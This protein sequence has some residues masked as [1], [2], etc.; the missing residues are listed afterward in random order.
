[1]VAALPMLLASCQPLTSQAPPPSACAGI[2]RRFDELIDRYINAAGEAIA[3]VEPPQALE[4][5]RKAVQAG[6]RAASI[7][8]VGIPL[9]LRARADRFNVATVRQVCGFAEANRHPLHIVACAYFNAL[10]PIG[11]RQSK[12]AIVEKQLSAFAVLPVNEPDR[13][14]VLASHAQALIACIE[15]L[16]RQAPV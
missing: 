6:D 4:R 10:N 14:D 11:N 15:A 16:P 5:A 8:V 7:V 1:M 12:L 3:R 9:M 2:E 13:N